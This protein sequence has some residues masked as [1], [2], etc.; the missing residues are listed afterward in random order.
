MTFAIEPGDTTDLG[1]CDCC[2][3]RTRIVVGFVSNEAGAR[4]VYHLRW[5]P[6]R[7]EHDAVVAVSI[8]GWGGGSVANRVCFALA[9][10][11]TPSPG[12]MLVDAGA[13]PWATSEGLLGRMTSRADALTSPLKQ[14]V[15]DILDAIGEKDRRVN[16]W[17]LDGRSDNAG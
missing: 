5:A 16:A 13:S 14:E 11:I 17:W 6:G 2:G 3:G 15:F 8:G 12:F 4:A 7:P 9:L 10:R 1:P